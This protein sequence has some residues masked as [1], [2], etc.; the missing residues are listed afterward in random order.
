MVL[1]AKVSC[2]RRNLDL[3][4]GTRTSRLSSD[5]SAL[6]AE[7]KGFHLSESKELSLV[8]DRNQPEE[9]PPNLPGFLL[10]GYKAVK[11]MQNFLGFRKMYNIPLWIICGGAMIGFCLAR[12]VRNPSGIVLVV[13]DGAFQLGCLTTTERSWLIT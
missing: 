7:E 10:P 13:T 5:G 9:V 4:A 3:P 8:P 1:A 2:L 12:C 6:S 11:A